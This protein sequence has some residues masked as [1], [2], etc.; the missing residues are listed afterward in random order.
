MCGQGSLFKPQGCVL[1]AGPSTVTFSPLHIGM[2]TLWA[3]TALTPGS[4]APA[5]GL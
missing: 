2:R 1:R 5:L 3:S 4:S